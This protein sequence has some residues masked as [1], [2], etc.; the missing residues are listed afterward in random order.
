MFLIYHLPEYYGK[1]GVVYQRFN[2]DAIKYMKDI[3]AIDKK[4]GRSNMGM[5][6]I[7]RY[8][9][10]LHASGAKMKRTEGAQ[11]QNKFDHG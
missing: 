3:E 10:H 6:D 8:K 4:K 1:Y 9:V 11:H 2:D 7:S 5:M